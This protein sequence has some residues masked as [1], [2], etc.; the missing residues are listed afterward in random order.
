[1][2][3][4]IAICKVTPVA[5]SGVKA[6]SQ[7]DESSPET[8]RYPNGL[9]I[10]GYAVKT[11]SEGIEHVRVSPIGASR[12]QWIRIC[13]R[14]GSHRLVDIEY[15]V[16]PHSELAVSLTQIAQTQADLTVE[17]RKLTVAVFANSKS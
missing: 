14:D 11:S 2:V 12:I 8:G 10:W 13:E 17:I 6:R 4:E 1:M 16:D 5:L 9:P 3:P 15:L 7:M